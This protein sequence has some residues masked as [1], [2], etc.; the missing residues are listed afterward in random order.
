MAR[1]DPSDESWVL[2]QSR[3]PK[4]CPQRVKGEQEA[5]I[6]VMRCKLVSEHR[7]CG[8]QAILWEREAE[9]L[10]SAALPSL[11]TVE[12]ILHRHRDDEGLAPRREAN[13]K[14]RYRPRGKCYPAPTSGRANLLHQSDFVG[15][16]YLTGGTR[17]YSLHVVDVATRRAAVEPS[18]GRDDETVLEA[19]WRIWCRLGKPRCLQLDNEMTF[20]GSFRYAR[21]TGQLIRL[22][23]MEHIEP[24]FIPMREPWRNGIVEKFN[25]YYQDKLLGPVTIKN[26]RH[27]REASLGFEHRH[28]AQ[29]RYA[30]LQ[31]KTPNE[32]FA[33]E[34]GR[35]ARLRLPETA[36]L[37]E[38]PLPRAKTGRYRLIRFIRSDRKLDIFG[39]AFVMPKKAVYEY[40]TATVDVKEQLLCVKLEE[41]L[42]ATI[43]YKVLH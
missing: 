17:F 15:P 28:N 36:E 29:F 7:F 22:C 26:V 13:A 42:I 18:E 4:T 35:H 23:L 5:E 39:E 25:D 16:C 14:S 12:R 20:F 31:G 11:R 6:I 3:R 1:Y 21:A 34:H 24:V 43:D 38:L 30:Y 37:P 33:L 10:R 40:V 19:F 27:L 8:P 2:D 41:E 32:A 9:D